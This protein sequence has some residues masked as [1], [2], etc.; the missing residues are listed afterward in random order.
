MTPDVSDVC[1]EGGHSDGNSNRNLFWLLARRLLLHLLP[2][3]P[4]QRSDH[5]AADALPA[6]RYHNCCYTTHCTQTWGLSVSDIT[7]CV[8]L[9]G[10][11]F[12]WSLRR[13]PRHLQHPL[14]LSV[15]RPVA[16]AGRPVNAAHGENYISHQPLLPLTQPW[17]DCVCVRVCV[18]QV[19]A[20]LSRTV[21][22][23]PRLL[24]CGTLSLLHM[25]FLL[26]LHFAY[27]KIV[28]GQIWHHFLSSCDWTCV[29]CQSHTSCLLF[30]GCWTLWKDPTWPRC[31]GWPETC[32]SWPWT[33]HWG[34]RGRCWGPAEVQQRS[35]AVLLRATHRN[36]FSCFLCPCLYI[37]IVCFSVWGFY[38]VVLCSDVFI[39]SVQTLINFMDFIC[40]SC[41]TITMTMIYTFYFINI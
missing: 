4:G 36:I 14:P 7:S 32:L 16:A 3:V 11:R 8:L 35:R 5:H 1:A 31:S 29:C 2:G 33:P 27:H 34:S 20:L 41:W 15:L 28:E 24:L 30:Q 18:C 13:P 25:L 19:A 22:H 10:L 17:S 40:L 39:V 26:Y 12:V 23:T 9:P 37:L 21:G 38:F 6:G